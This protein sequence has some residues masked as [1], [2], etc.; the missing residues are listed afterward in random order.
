MLV[1]DKKHGTWLVI[2]LDHFEIDAIRTALQG[3]LKV[4]SHVSETWGF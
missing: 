1:K 4:R 2:W 3:F